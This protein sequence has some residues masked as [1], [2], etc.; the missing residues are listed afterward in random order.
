MADSLSSDSG[1]VI[2]GRYRLIAPLG[3]GSGGQAYLADDIRLRRQ[4]AVRVLRRR[5]ADD[6]SFLERFRTQAETATSLN[7][8]NIVSIY[9]WGDKELPF[10]V[11]EYLPGGS[12]REML[13]EAGALTPS[14]ALLVGIEVSKGLEYAH[15]RGVIHQALK[16]ANILFDAGS[17]VRISDF[18]VAKTVAEATP[19]DINEPSSLTYVSPEQAQGRRVDTHSDI[20]S[21]SLILYRCVAGQLSSDTGTLVSDL[22]FPLDLDTEKFGSLAAPISKGTSTDPMERPTA[23]NF[24]KLL[25]AATSSQSRPKSLPISSGLEMGVLSSLEEDPTLVDLIKAPNNDSWIKRV[26]NKIRE[27]I[28]RWIWLIL[29]LAVVA[30]VVGGIYQATNKTDDISIQ[31]IPEVT[32]LSVQ[33]LF[34]KVG[35]FWDL[36]EAFD[37]LDGTQEGT[38]LRTNPAA[39]QELQE[40]ETVTYFV[41]QGSELQPVPVNLIGIAVSDAETLLQGANL[42]LGEITEQVNEEFSN[43]TVVAVVTIGQ[44]LPTGSPVDLVVSL[45][46]VLRTIP[47]G[48]AGDTVEDAQMKLVLEGLQVEIEDKYHDEIPAGIVIS[49]SP[50]SSTQ[51]PRETS[52]LLRVSLGPKPPEG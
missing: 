17:N 26:F 39:G 43:G 34:D 25:L 20:F 27:R 45:G 31:V 36:R 37:R 13:D 12:L 21:L 30:T 15:R 42:V 8:E 33:E 22:E 41:S 49:V 51:V 32:G 10:V 9:D 52:I 1:M 46:P 35:N 47:T 11:S 19:I 44:E 38:I 40:G 4:V 50:E 7:H 28:G 16:P 24:H 2:N 5:Y 14:Q 3:V 6:Q 48:L 29:M 23:G 18:G